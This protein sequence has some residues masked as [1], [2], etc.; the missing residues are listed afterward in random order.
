MGSDDGR[1]G[2]RKQG[3][4][5]ADIPAKIAASFVE[6]AACRGAPYSARGRNFPEINGQTGPH[7]ENMAETAAAGIIVSDLAGGLRS[8]GRCQ[9][10]AADPARSIALMVAVL[11]GVFVGQGTLLRSA[12]H[13]S[14]REGRR[15]GRCRPAAT[16]YPYRF[17]EGG[18]TILVPQGV[19]HDTRLKLAAQGLPKGGWSASN[20]WKTRRWASASSPNR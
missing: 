3:N 4:G 12:V 8:P 20:C 6:S 17:S 11:V 7:R 1:I 5:L 10:E 13:D 2:A 16:E 9:P 19:V 14:G 18:H 15:P